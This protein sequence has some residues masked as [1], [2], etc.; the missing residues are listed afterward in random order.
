MMSM[1]VPMPM[2]V[3]FLSGCL[4][5]LRSLFLL[6]ERED[7]E[8]LNGLANLTLIFVVNSGLKGFGQNLIVKNF[9][10][11]PAQLSVFHTKHV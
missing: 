10:R 5:L 6:I 9:E 7:H 11:Y 8:R 1:S 4:Q 2:M 3:M